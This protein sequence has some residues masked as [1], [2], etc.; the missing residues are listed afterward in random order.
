MQKISSHF[1]TQKLYCWGYVATTIVYI[2]WGPHTRRLASAKEFAVLSRIVIEVTFKNL[3]L[4]LLV[5][6]HEARC[7]F[8]NWPV[9]DT[10]SRVHVSDQKKKIN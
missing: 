1:T 2:C 5:I 8:E 7:R 9:P 4:F 10:N 6:T 3:I